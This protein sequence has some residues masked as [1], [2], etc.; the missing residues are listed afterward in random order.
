MSYGIVP[1][2]YGSGPGGTGTLYRRYSKNAVDWH[3]TRQPDDIFGQLSIDNTNWDAPFVLDSVA[4]VDIVATP[5][6]KHVMGYN[7]RG[8]LF[9]NEH[10]TEAATNATF[11]SWDA[12]SSRDNF[13]GAVAYNPEGFLEDDNAQVYNYNL[14]DFFQLSCKPKRLQLKRQETF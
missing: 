1:P 13:E 10:Y 2:N 6:A 4:N 8:A 9:A 5:T 7:Q 14:H 12:I 3:A 11:D